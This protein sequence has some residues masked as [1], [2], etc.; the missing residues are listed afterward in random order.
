[1]TRTP[2]TTITHSAMGAV[3][4][5][6][7][8]SGPVIAHGDADHAKQAAPVHIVLNNNGA[9]LHEFVLGSKGELDKHA[10]LMAKF[11]TME[12]DEPSM[13]HVPPG[14]TGQIIWID[15]RG[16][17]FNFACLIA[18]HDQAGMVG[19]VNVSTIPTPIPTPIPTHR[20]S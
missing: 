5:L 3:A 8:A 14:K 19:E 13:A 11:P 12:H 18:G 16:G 6:S 1:M 2:M 17:D 9:V 10:A 15:N 20:R 4:A 7:L